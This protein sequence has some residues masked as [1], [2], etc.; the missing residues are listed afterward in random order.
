MNAAVRIFTVFA[1]LILP[2]LGED[3]VLLGLR[4]ALN[5]FSPVPEQTG[6]EVRTAAAEVLARY[7][8]PQKGT[9]L[10]QQLS[11]SSRTWTETAGL[12]LTRVTANAV[13][14]ADQANGVAESYLVSVDGEMYR[15]Y[16]SAASRWSKWYNGRNLF[17]PAAITVQ[18]GKNGQW[19][20]STTDLAR[21]IM[22]SSK[23]DP[24]SIPHGAPPPQPRQPTVGSNP[25]PQFPTPTRIQSDPTAVT[26]SRIKQNPPFS[27]VMPL[28]AA[29]VV[30]SS[31]IPFFTMKAKKRR[32]RPTP[33]GKVTPP[34]LPPRESAARSQ[35]T[36]SRDP[37]AAYRPPVQPLRSGETTPSLPPL[38]SSETKPDPMTL[39]QRREHLLTPAELAFFEVLEPVVSASCRISTKVRLADLFDVRP[40]QGQQSAFNKIVGKHVD[41]V[42]TDPKTSRILGAIELDDSSH[43]RPDRQERD[44]FVNELFKIQKVPLI[45]VP[46]AWRYDPETIRANLADAGLPA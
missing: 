17:L 35:A 11:G 20:A 24:E 38:E 19:T 18:R 29:A 21:L 32:A 14:Q 33:A 1:I 2:A 36:H 27:N 42:L 46:F 22:F 12:N 13:S 37:D 4:G 23:G 7:V 3:P 16:D 15:T 30:F 9:W 10:S 26:P 5:V 41:F 28:L 44:L 34:P 8:K 39:M 25:L 40:G 6:F 43:Q 31:A 45:R